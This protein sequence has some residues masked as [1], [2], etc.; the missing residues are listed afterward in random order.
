M[1]SV[2]NPSDFQ[3]EY[4]FQLA[5]QTT[6][7][8]ESQAASSLGRITLDGNGGVTGY[9]SA[10]FSG[11]LQGNP[12]TGTYEA[13]TDC[14]VTWQLQDDSGGYQHFSGVATPGA[15]S[16]RFKQTDPGGL[17]DG[18]MTKTATEC[19]VTDLAK[20]YDVTF[21]GSTSAGE[22]SAQGEMTGD[23]NGNFKLTRK[24]NTNATDVT[25]TIQP[26][27]T[28]NLVI[29]LPAEHGHATTEMNLQGV[30][31]VGKQILAIQTDP[32]N[33]VAAKFTAR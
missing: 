2:C 22:V 9:A 28:V 27:C 21:S 17:K 6:I 23:G 32:G 8:G 24:G 19:Q 13:K 30:V 12:V 29:E 1:A 16:V 26:D 14:T 7:S 25:I 3:G 31:T 10:M 15:Q 18:L 5:G 33:M 4:T 20:Q 11:V